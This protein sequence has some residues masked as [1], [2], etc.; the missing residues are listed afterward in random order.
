MNAYSKD[1]RLGVLGAVDRSVPRG[2]VVGLFGVSLT[3]LK[4]WLKHRR[5]GKDLAPK[6]SPGRTPRILSTAE[7]ETGAVGATRGERRC[8]AGASP[9]AV[10][11]RAR[12]KGVGGD[13]E[14][15]DPQAGLDLKKEHGCHRARR[16]REKCLERANRKPRS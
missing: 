4:R 7:R 5:E 12:G 11:A 1:L 9:R 15:A 3:T 2:E 14:P 6:P 13:D 10:K 16:R 8:H